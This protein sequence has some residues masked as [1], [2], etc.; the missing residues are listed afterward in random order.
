MARRYR[1]LAGLGLLLLAALHADPGRGAVEQARVSLKTGMVL[2]RGAAIAAGEYKLSSADFDHPALTIRGSNLTIDFAGATLRGASASADPDSFA[3]V[4]VF[5]DGGENVTIRNLTARGYKVGILARGARRL[6]ITGSDLS[7]NWKSRLYSGV[8]HESLADWLSYHH[9][10]KDEWLAGGAGIYLADCDEPEVDRTTIVQGQNGLMLVRS[11]AAK[12]W[13]NTFSFL[14]G[15]GIGLYRADRNTIVHNRVDWCVRGYSHTFYNRGQDSAGILIY[16]QSSRNIVAFNSVTHGGDGLFLW[17]GQSTMD[18]GEGGANDNVVYDNDF[19][20]APA[21]G[22]EA[23][24]SR[25]VL[26]GNRIE[27]CW[28]GVWGGYSYDTWIAANRFKRNVEGIAIEHGQDNRITENV[29]DGDE[30]AVHLWKNPSQDPDWGYPKRRD[31]RS[32]DYVISGNTF[33]NNTTALKIADTQGLRILTNAFDKVGSVAVLSGDTRNLG[34]GDEITVPVRNRPT[35]DV[36]LPTPLPEGMNAKIPD[37]DRRG[38]DAIIVDEWGPYDWKHPKLWPAGRSDA[39]P[40][41]LRVLG[42]AGEWQLA[43]IRGATATPSA[44]KVPGTITVTPASAAT[45]D[46]D[47]RLTYHGAATVSPRGDAFPAGAAYTFGY[48]RYFVPVD[49]DVEYFAFDESTSPERSDGAFARITSGTPLKSDRRPRLDFM[50]GRSIA[51]GVPPDRVAIVAEGIVDLP[52]GSYEIRT[53]SDD[54]I[55][56]W[57]DDERVIDH[58]TPHESAIDRAPLTGGRRKLKV[59]YFEL[60]GFA[61]LR[62]EILRR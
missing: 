36:T 50:S 40:L 55:R 60:G 49:W 32:R 2:T 12:V 61:E 42:P 37:A 59:E 26:Y 13:N 14:S 11:H 57:V 39:A 5:V 18:S 34:I 48:S 53:I 3:G 51:D 46:F 15:V 47:V 20:F 62:L 41:T 1:K 27:D 16:E 21:N 19:S 33:T 28:H 4:A 52:A 43:S 25:N 6:H 31:T 9:N 54:A 44:G 56:V 7:Y 10:E 22:I 58:W 38:R 24:F 30:T 35:L 29:F 45:I 8:E 17:A 23:T